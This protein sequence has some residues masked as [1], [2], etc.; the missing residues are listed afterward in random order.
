MGNKVEEKELDT[1]CFLTWSLSLKEMCPQ[2][3]TADTPDNRPSHLTKTLAALRVHLHVPKST[4]DLSMRHNSGVKGGAI[5][6]STD[7]LHHL[8]SMITECS[9]QIESDHHCSKHNGP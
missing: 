8:R 7:P 9:T 1:R 5:F 4:R 6:S 2:N 3:G